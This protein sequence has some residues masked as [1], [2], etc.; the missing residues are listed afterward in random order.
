M[1]NWT[2][3]GNEKTAV[4]V[5]GEVS[6]E[7]PQTAF[8]TASREDDSRREAEDEKK[9]RLLEERLALLQQE[10]SQSEAAKRDAA[11]VQKQ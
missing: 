10:L 5:V 7:P 3:I 6:K 4:S 2:K 9:Q 1:K 11:S 8:K